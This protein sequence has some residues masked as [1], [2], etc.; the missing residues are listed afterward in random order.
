[1]QNI[2]LGDKH[3]SNNDTWVLVKLYYSTKSITLNF[4]L[5]TDNVCTDHKKVKNKQSKSAT[6]SSVDSKKFYCLN[7]Q[8]INENKQVFFVEK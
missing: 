8:I 5:V 7:S 1:M 3:T 6:L 4:K 2:N